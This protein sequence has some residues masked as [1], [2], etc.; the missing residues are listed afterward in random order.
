MTGL[1]GIGA[2]LASPMV[3]LTEYV[4][5]HAVVGGQFALVRRQPACMLNQPG[6]GT[7]LQR[8]HF[9][10]PG[11][12]GDHPGV[13][14]VAVIVTNKVILK[15]R[16]NLEQVQEIRIVMGQQVVQHPVPKQ[17]HLDRHRNRLRL[18]TDGTYQSIE[19][20]QGLDADFT[21]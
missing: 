11:H 12:G 8:P 1:D 21:G 3:S 14:L 10:G 16:L 5:E 2:R 9:Q 20:L 17:N 15:I 4:P 6:Y 19:P 7:S 13:E 18:Q